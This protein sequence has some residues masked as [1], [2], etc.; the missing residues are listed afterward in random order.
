MSTHDEKTD[1]GSAKPE[2]TVSRRDF[3]RVTGGV[4]GAALLAACGATPASPSGAASGQTAASASTDAGTTGGATAAAV[5]ATQA[6]AAAAGGAA[7]DVQFWDMVWGPPAYIDTAKKV[8]QQ[9]TQANPNIKA[10]YQ[11]NPWSSWPQVFT[12]AVGSGTA[13]DVSTGGGYQA[14]QFYPQGAILE[15]DDVVASFKPDDFLPNQIEGM[16]FN[17]H[18]VALPWGIDIRIPFYRKDLFDKAGVKPPTNW[19]E[20]RAGLKKLTSGNQ[21]G[22]AFPGNDNAAWQGMWGL[23]INNGGGL[24]TADRKLDVMNDRTVEAL[25]FISNL[26]K[27]GVVHPGSAGFS[28]DDM[29]KAFSSGSVGMVIFVPGTEERVTPNVKQNVELLAPMTGPHGDKGT[30]LFS[31]NLMVYKQTKNPDAT[32][33]FLKW[34][35]ANSLPIW[36]EGKCG[37]LPARTSIAKDPYFQNNIYLKRILDEWVPIGK[38][39]GTRSS[40]TFPALADI[41]MGG[42]MKT[43]AT[44]ILQ[45]QDV[46]ASLQKLETTLKGLK[47]LQS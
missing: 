29:T 7:G 26:V 32:K 12:T 35:S 4:A 10:S 15:I 11:S 16:K 46:K 39:T 33:S 5:Q 40:G 41:D 37:N 8:V 28:G 13:P 43:L 47:T 38:L 36:T 23:V 25:T 42:M 9:F 14:I 17:G 24:F 19:D 3:L 30:L 31:N 22:I 2:R 18:Y 1:D 27:D 44:D 20:M 45:G 6:P 34:W 21:Y